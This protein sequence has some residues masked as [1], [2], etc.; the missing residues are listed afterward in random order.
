M[1]VKEEVAERA[2]SQPWYYR[3]EVEPGKYTPG[4]RIGTLPT[5]RR[6]IDAIDFT[7]QRVLDIGTQEFVYPIL[8]EPKNPAEVVAYD[9]L[10]LTDQFAMLNDVYNLRRTKYVHGIPLG[11]LKQRLTS[12]GIDPVFDIVNFTGVLYHMADP[13]PGLA[14]ARSMLRENGLM[15]LETSVSSDDGFTA[16]CNNRALLYGGSNYFQVGA[17]VLDYWCRML[18]MKPVD[19]F[20][21]GGD[22]IKRLFIVMHATDRVIAEVEDKWIRKRFARV[23][24]E[25]F[26]LFYDELASD[27]PKVGYDRIRGFGPLVFTDTRPKYLDVYAT[28]KG[29]REIPFQPAKAIVTLADKAD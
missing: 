16:E 13:L 24:F 10:S 2:L 26:G 4:R 12:D 19:C 3:I 14:M 21:H 9:R 20:W 15:V 17:K 7:G 6:I 18:R 27:K 1:A 29:R 5:V 25:P 23:D 22:R 28:A 11:D 8:V